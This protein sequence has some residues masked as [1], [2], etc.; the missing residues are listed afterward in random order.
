MDLL[1]KYQAQF[2]LASEGGIPPYYQEV[3]WAGPFSGQA[4]VALPLSHPPTNRN[5]HNDNKIK[6]TEDFLQKKPSKKQS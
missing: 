6:Y 1:A 2:P 4:A 5:I 3:R